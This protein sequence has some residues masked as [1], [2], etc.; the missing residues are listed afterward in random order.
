MA[1][2]VLLPHDWFPRPLPA[3]VVI[4]PR[5]WLYSSFAFVHCRSRRPW[6]VRIGHDSGLYVG[7]YFELGCNGEVEIGNYC[8]IVGAVIRTDHRVV[9]EDYA[10]VSHDVVIADSFAAPPP[11]S[12]GDAGLPPEPW[13][14]SVAVR[15]N[16]WVGTRAVLLRGAD[17]GEGAI[18]GA[19]AVVDFLVPAYAVVAGN[20]ARVVG[21][22][23]GRPPEGG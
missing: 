19:G 9:I 22:A 14:V 7:T 10:L 16:A 8:T 11:E 1:E 4:G 20:P 23:R 2:P 12:T 21:W 6:A 17:V 5:S 13:L 18:V 15:R 3:N